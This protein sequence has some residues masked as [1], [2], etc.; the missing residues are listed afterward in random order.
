MGD[1]IGRVRGSRTP[2]EDLQSPLIWAHGD[3]QRLNHQPKRIKGLD[4]GPYTFIADMEVG[5]HVGALNN[6][7]RGYY[8]YTDSLSYYWIPSPSWTAWLRPQWER[9]CLVLLFEI[10]Q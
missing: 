10:P 9:M 8:Y 5:L 4:L 1:S 7:G 6:Q 2:E 3:S